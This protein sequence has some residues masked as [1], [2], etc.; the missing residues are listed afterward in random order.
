MPLN[1]LR[2][3]SV[4]EEMVIVGS[5]EEPLSALGAPSSS[6]SPWGS[7]D[8]KASSRDDEILERKLDIVLLR[9]LESGSLVEVVLALVELH[10]SRDCHYHKMGYL[11]SNWDRNRVWKGGIVKTKHLASHQPGHRSFLFQGLLQMQMQ[12]HQS[13]QV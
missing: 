4:A 8:S 6:I 7:A 3:R 9:G 10:S 2:I 12:L 5:L 1:A 11:A 13:L